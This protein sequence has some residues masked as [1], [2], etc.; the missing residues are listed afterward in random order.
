M[1]D[2]DQLDP[3]MGQEQPEAGGEIQHP[4][5]LPPEEKEHQ[6]KMAKA[7]LFKLA[8]YS[9]K[10][11]KQL[12]D[13]DQ[14]EAWVQAK[15]TKAADYMASVYHY[16]EYEMKFTE[17]GHHLDNSDTL[18]E[19]QKQVL[20]NRL[21]EAKNK[22]KELK[23]AQAEK[24]KEEKSSTGGEISH[25][26][27]GVT[28]HT[29]NPDRFTDEPHAEPASKAKSRSAAEKKDEKA[30]DKADEK[31]SKAWGK[32]NP[33][34]QTIMKGGVKTT[35]EMF[36]D[37]D[38]VGAK[39]KTAHG[40]A[41]KTSTGLKHD[42]DYGDDDDAESTK[43]RSAHKQATKYASKKMEEAKDK[44]AK[45]DWDQDGKIESGKDEYLGS[46]IRAAKKA[47]KM[48][49]AK[50][51]CCEE[52]GKAKCPVHGPKMMEAT[53]KC[54]CEEKGKAKC[55][56]HGPKKTV[57]E[58]RVKDH[59]ADLVHAAAIVAGLKRRKDMPKNSK[60]SQPEMDAGMDMGGDEM[61]GM[62]MM[63][64]EPERYVHPDVKK[65]LEK[66]GKETEAMAA[67]ARRINS[68]DA[69]SEFQ[70]S[71]EKKTMS[72][73]AKGMMKYGKDG[74]KALA[75]A[76]KEGKDLDK[77]RDKYDKYDES[78]KPSAGLS[79]AK[80]SATVKAA[81]KG[82]DIGKPGKGF[83]ALAKKAG[84]GEK[85]EKIAAAAMWKNIKETT[86]YMMEKKAASKKDLP[87]NQEKIDVDHDGKIEASDLAKLRAKKETKE[88]TDF[89]RMQ[90]QMARLNRT[91]QPMIA[92][93]REVDQI[94]AL[95]KRL[96]G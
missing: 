46:K 87:G 37:D 28:R 21:M 23:K 10:L 5:E 64:Q 12:H 68:K 15:I 83:K 8:T 56:V 71:A 51:C 27:P 79:A 3:A 26:K 61:G 72:R 18:S 40:T 65:K 24:I 20:K 50:K 22:M 36:S 44:K 57:D 63:H 45:K 82:E 19:G 52:K 48:D 13:E 53:A 91:E 4:L 25:P 43:E 32:A 74:M 54:C 86:A 6:G 89:T 9:H 95:T 88:S 58:S 73:A 47:G 38:K 76:G 29:H 94:R 80:K 92:E 1:P 59:H 17:Y 34:K 81:K 70:E 7:D 66:Y 60:Q 11:F 33:G 16:L 30:M 85:G 78:A 14:L 75:K 77:V 84:G 35:N 67:A 62:P 39:K 93:S 96:L 55:P 49:E 90:E 2:L 42:R 41:T 31:E 69:S